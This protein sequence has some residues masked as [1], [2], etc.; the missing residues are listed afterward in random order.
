M[1]EEERIRI[2]NKTP[3]IYYTE[4]QLKKIALKKAKKACKI[5]LPNWFVN[6]LNEPAEADEDKMMPAQAAA[7]PALE[8]KEA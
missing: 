3:V 8:Q 6:P 1:A 7:E 4:A 5:N 2:L